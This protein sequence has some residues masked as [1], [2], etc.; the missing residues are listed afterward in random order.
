MKTNSKVGIVKVHTAKKLRNGSHLAEVDLTKLHFADYQRDAIPAHVRQINEAWD[1]EFA[2]PL[3]VSVRD[4]RLWCIDGRQTATA[5]LGSAKK[6]S[7]DFKCI[8]T[9]LDAFVWEGWS[10][11][12]EALAFYTYNN[13]P[14]QQNGWK[15]FHASMKAGNL[16]NMEILR[17]LHDIGLTTPYH[18]AISKNKDADVTHCGVILSVMQKGGYPLVKAWAKAMRGWK[19]NGVMPETAKSCDFGRALRDFLYLGDGYSQRSTS[20]FAA[21]KIVTPDQI[22]QLAKQIDKVDRPD[23]TQIRRAMEQL[24][25]TTTLKKAA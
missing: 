7:G 23:L 9:T 11:Q 25:L 10:Y 2:R 1:D 12:R 22:R 20:V 18:A 6:S 21:L 15:K 16:V 4:G 19:K 24:T 5:A 8:S 13:A 14:V 17:I 3:I